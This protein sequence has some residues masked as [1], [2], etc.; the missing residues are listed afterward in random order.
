MQCFNTVVFV[1][2]HV[3]VFCLME[4]SSESYI[5]DYIGIFISHNIFSFYLETA[6]Y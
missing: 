2:V 6:I 5:A 4:V 1:E 3:T